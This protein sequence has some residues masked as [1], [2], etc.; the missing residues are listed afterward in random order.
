MRPLLVVPGLFCTEIHDQDLGYVWGRFRQ[1]YWGPPIGAP[2]GLRGK[3]GRILRGLPLPF[4]QSLNSSAHS[5]AR[6]W[7]AGTAWARRCTSLPTIGASRWS[8]W[9]WRW[10]PRR[11]GSPPPAARRSTCSVSPTAGQSSARPTRPTRRCRSS[12]WSP[13]AART[14]APSRR[15]PASTPAFAS[16]RWAARSRRRS[17]C[18]APAASIRSP[19]LPGPSSCPRTPATTSTTSTPGGGCGCR[20]SGAIP[21]TRPG[22]TS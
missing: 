5:S 11:A 18:P 10:R 1:L 20:C 4:G 21:T 9:G 13:P 8:T 22:S 3:P 19:A 17:S 2:S 7:T 16:R 15:W 6:C 12:A 14:P